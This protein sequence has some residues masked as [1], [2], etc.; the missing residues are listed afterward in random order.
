MF[1]LPL[2]N[3]I[4]RIF[5]KQLFTYVYLKITLN[6]FAIDIMILIINNH[7]NIPTCLEY[8]LELG[9]NKKKTFFVK[10]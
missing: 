5:I 8:E 4:R 9:L 10:L 6:S 7:F 3:Y 1:L 2:P